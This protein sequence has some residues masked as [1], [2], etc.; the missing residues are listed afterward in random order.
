[1]SQEYNNNIT[2]YICHIIY[3]DL[4]LYHYIIHHWLL[5]LFVF[6][7][8]EWKLNSAGPEAT[9]EGIALYTPNI[10]QTHQDQGFRIFH[11][12]LAAAFHLSN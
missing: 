3:A 1:M 10:R 7:F 5:S 9:L 2:I 12:T 8:S 4:L 6:L 11:A